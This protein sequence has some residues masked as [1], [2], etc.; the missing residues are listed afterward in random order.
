MVPRAPAH[1]STEFAD[2]DRASRTTKGLGCRWCPRF[3]HI[4]APRCRWCSR[5]THDQGPRLPT[6]SEASAYHSTEHQG[7]DGA[8]GSRTTKGL[9]CRQ[10]PRLPHIIA[11]RLLHDQGLSLLM[12]SGAPAHPSTKVPMVPE[13]PAHP[14]TKLPLESE[15]PVPMVPEAP[16]RPR[17]EVPMVAEAPARPRAYFADGP[18]LPMVP[19]VLVHP[20]TKVPMVLEAPARPWALLQDHGL[21]LLMVSGADGARGS[22]KTKDLVCSW[23]PGLLHILAPRCRWCRYCP[24]LPHIRATKVPMVP[25]AP[26]QPRA[27]VPM[28][29]EAP[30]QPRAYFADGARGSRVTNS[31]VCRWCPSLSHDQGPRLPMVPEVLAHPS[32]EVSMVLE[33]PARPWAAPAHRSTEVPIAPEAPA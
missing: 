19:E 12:V 1:R 27:E 7:A 16:A 11:P 32:T 15:A 6:V 2:G 22:Y 25:E 8:R 33:V 18:R 21:S 24:R 20:S 4:Q 26:A 14:S 3:P 5:L 23:C 9:G 17:A 28:V 31:L 10:C 13:S 30:A 29:A